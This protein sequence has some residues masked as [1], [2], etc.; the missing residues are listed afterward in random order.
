MSSAGRRCRVRVLEAGSFNDALRSLA[1]VEGDTPGDGL[2]NRDA[3]ELGG[4]ALCSEAG[5]SIRTD[6]VDLQLGDVLRVQRCGSSEECLVRH[7]DAGIIGGEDHGDAR[8]ASSE[9]V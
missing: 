6:E 2:I 4:N 9:E 1:H 8:R 7:T 5:G 3:D